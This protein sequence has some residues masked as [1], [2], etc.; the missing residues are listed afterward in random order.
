MNAY[1]GEKTFAL[2]KSEHGLGDS[3][4]GNF[5]SRIKRLI[6]LLG[7]YIALPVAYLNEAL[8]KENCMQTRQLQHM[9]N[10]DS[11]IGLRHCVKKKR[12]E[13]MAE[14]GD[15]PRKLT[16]LVAKEGFQEVVRY[17]PLL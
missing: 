5:P 4:K 9:E 1:S 17:E 7:H 14:V 13:K 6:D 16:A 3:A 15:G 11:R 2:G 8:M 12:S 10:Y